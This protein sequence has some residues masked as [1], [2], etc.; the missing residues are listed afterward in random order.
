MHICCTAMTVE[1]CW[2]HLSPSCATQWPG[3]PVTHQMVLTVIVGVVTMTQVECVAGQV[4][5]C[6]RITNIPDQSR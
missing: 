2:G 1:M 3:K 4:P 5:Q 6:D